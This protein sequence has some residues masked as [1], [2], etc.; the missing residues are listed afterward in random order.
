MLLA[1]NYF[2]L[3][4]DHADVFHDMFAESADG[5]I[6]YE[7]EFHNHV[8]QLR[9]N[10]FSTVYILAV[11]IDPNHRQK[12]LASMLLDY[13]LFAFEPAN[14]VA[15]VSNPQILPLLKERSFS[16]SNIAKDYFYV[17]RDERG[18]FLDSLTAVGV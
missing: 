3:K 7:E 10:G 17:W 1:T 8:E 14:F 5:N 4:D 11:C 13:A 2:K 18:E 9:G 12:G 6:L 15:D 16:V